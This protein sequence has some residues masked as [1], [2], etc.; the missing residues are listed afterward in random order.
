[1]DLALIKPR[2]E[3]LLVTA[4]VYCGNIFVVHLLVDT[5]FLVALYIRADPLHHAAVDFLKRNRSPLL[6][7]APV[8]V[9]T[10]FFLNAKGKTA[11]LG[12]VTNGGLDVVDI[13]VKSYPVL[14]DYIFKY[15]DQ[16]IDFADAALV[17]L[18]NQ[19]GQRCI[20]TVDETA[21]RIYRLASGQ[22]FELIRWYEN[23]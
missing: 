1:M 15:A 14:A 7:V 13:P 21:F 11:L 8:I 20:L 9:E 4:K 19:I 23:H 12:W 17:W 2:P 18:A 5:C 22:A 10:C 6:T 16:D 3:T